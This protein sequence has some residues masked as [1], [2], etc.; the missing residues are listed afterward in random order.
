[1]SRYWLRL[2]SIQEGKPI[3][4]CLR[5]RSWVPNRR[6]APVVNILEHG[7]HAIL[8][9][10]PRFPPQLRAD[11]GDIG[12][13][14][15]RFSRTFGNVDALVANQ[16]GEFSHRLGFASSKIVYALD[17]IGD[18]RGIK[19]PRHVGD[20]KKIARLA[21][22]AHNG[23]RLTRQFL[24]KH[25]PEDRAI[26]SRGARPNSVSVEDADDIHRKAVDQ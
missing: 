23:Q 16:S 8:E 15:F 21:A 3:L 25:D 22:I 1:M 24:R 19:S 6:L 10:N 26:S 7:L 13:G 17:P 11:S 18:R 5:D 20:I 9:R 4:R 12:P 14:A 2:L